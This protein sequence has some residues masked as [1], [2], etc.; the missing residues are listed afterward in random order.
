[1]AYVWFAC[2]LVTLALLISAMIDISV[3]KDELATY[4]MKGLEDYMAQ[5]E[6]NGVSR[7]SKL[8]AREP[9]LT[10]S[11]EKRNRWWSLG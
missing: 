4:R 6:G 1:M 8:S 5:K 2:F 9:V 11:Q 10:P 3:L 7:D